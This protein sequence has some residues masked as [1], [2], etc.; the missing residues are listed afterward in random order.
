MTHESLNR[1]LI[2]RPLTADSKS[3]IFILEFS[4]EMNARE[5]DSTEK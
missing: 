5:T 2:D 4:H 1:L 3:N